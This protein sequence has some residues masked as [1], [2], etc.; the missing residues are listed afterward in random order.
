M[1]VLKTVEEIRRVLQ[2]KAFG[3]T[4]GFVPTMGCLH[5]GHLE[6]VK[7]AQS[8]ADVVVV[9]I[10]V[11]PLQFGPTEDFQKYPRTFEEDTNKLASLGVDFLFHPSLEELYPEGFS[12]KVNVG[13]LSSVLCGE[14][15]PGHFEGVATVCLKLFQITQADFGVFGEKDFQQLQVIRK[16]VSDL[17]LPIQILAHPTLREEDG[18]AMSSRNRFLDPAQRQLA[19]LL[20]KALNK[21]RMM[22]EQD[23][24]LPVKT[25]LA[26]FR[27]EAAPVS[28]QYAEITESTSLRAMPAET[29][30]ANLKNPRFFVAA[31]VGS[32]RLIDNISLKGMTG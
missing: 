17:N 11:N 9:S 31:L 24:T 20:P 22:A 19:G 30:L 18:L 25:L 8:K 1:Q 29:P 7:Q 16:M 2:A 15:R 4:V 14:Y 32:T 10:F 6:L 28:I 3:K 5:A 27:N 21:V 23:P 13:Y 12:T 26:A